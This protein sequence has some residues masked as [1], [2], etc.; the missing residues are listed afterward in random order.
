MQTNSAGGV[1]LENQGPPSLPACTR[2]P[3]FALTPVKE[4]LLLVT[5]Y[6]V[7]RRPENGAPQNQS[8]R[9]RA[10]TVRCSASVP[11]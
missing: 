11:L 7:A 2:V 3:I 6:N 1:P 8:W 10:C 9:L 4:H 5:T